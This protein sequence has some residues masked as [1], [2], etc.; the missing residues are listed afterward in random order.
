M[1]KR[2]FDQGDLGG[3][4]VEK[5]IDELVDL[6]LVSGEGGET[7]FWSLV[8]MMWILAL[9]KLKQSEIEKNSRL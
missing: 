5:A 9:P 7:S 6:V 4:E 1:G 8:F 3:S 2:G